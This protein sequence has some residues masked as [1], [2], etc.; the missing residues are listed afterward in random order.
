M[1]HIHRR[2]KS[3]EQLLLHERGHRQVMMKLWHCVT[4]SRICRWGSA[5]R[6]YLWLSR[7]HTVFVCVCV[8]LSLN[9]LDLHCTQAREDAMRQEVK[10]S[11]CPPATM[12]PAHGHLMLLRLLYLA[13]GCL[14][15]DGQGAGCQPRGVSINITTGVITN[16][17]CALSSYYL[18]QE[19]KAALRR[20]Q[21]AHEDELA[22]SLQP[23]T[24]WTAALTT[25][26]TK[27]RQAARAR[28]SDPAP[29]SAVDAEKVANL[30]EQ[31][32]A[33]QQRIGDLQQEKVHT[34]VTLSSC[35]TRLTF[36]G[37]VCHGPSGRATRKVQ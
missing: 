9:I 12:H 19:A 6:R 17:P 24:V 27:H 31:L 16:S 32:D 10:C 11:N 3:D 15:Q 34:T 7:A 26:H 1:T 14:A 13:A 2:S 35:I 18:S 20:S 5:R 30:Q 22:V 33:A 21:Q 36:A 25:S 37:S 8:S 23:C 29:S 28:A 4:A